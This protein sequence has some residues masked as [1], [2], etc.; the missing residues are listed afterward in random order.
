MDK[1]SDRFDTMIDQALAR[2]IDTSRLDSQEL[3]KLRLTLSHCDPFFLKDCLDS[4]KEAAIIMPMT[5]KMRQTV[6]TDQEDVKIHATYSAGYNNKD[7]LKH[8]LIVD[9]ESPVKDLVISLAHELTHFIQATNGRY[10]IDFDG[11]P[12]PQELVARYFLAEAEAFAT[13]IDHAYEVHIKDPQLSH[14]WLNAEQRMPAFCRLYKEVRTKTLSRDKAFKATFSL[15]YYDEDLRQAMTDVALHQYNLILN[16][17]HGNQVIDMDWDHY[18][19]E[20]IWRGLSILDILPDYD[21]HSALYG[22]LSPAFNTALESLH[23]AIAKSINDARFWDIDF[24]DALEPEELSELIPFL[25]DVQTAPEHDAMIIFD[26]DGTLVN[27]D[28]VYANSCADILNDHHLPVT[29]EEMVHDFGG[30]SSM[31]RIRHGYYQAGRDFNEAEA[32][33]I[34]EKLRAAKATIYSDHSISAFNG[35]EKL[36][37]TLKDK[38]IKTVLGTSNRVPTL[39]TALSPEQTG[40]GKYF[41]MEDLYCGGTLLDEGKIDGM[42]PNPGNF[43]YAAE[44]Q[45]IAPHKVLVIGNSIQDAIGAK[46]AEMPFIGYIDSSH[47]D[48]D[49]IDCAHTQAMMREGAITVFSDFK[50]LQKFIFSKKCP[51]NF[52]PKSKPRKKPVLIATK[53]RP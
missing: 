5:A 31:D 34:Q 47:K 23:G 22:G 48:Y 38:D 51:I 29:Y 33:N 35:V 4:T 16:N 39:L 30:S 7:E 37:Q 49:Q 32:K 26:F 42:K 14:F 1:S 13:M 20:P 2:L 8:Y 17:Y 12:R 36:L 27:S 25:V 43:T 19:N 53:P 11:I 9:L 21:A 44:E 6:Q 10:P 50:T 24:H 52:E 3:N 46:A 15:F 41:E 28:S 40:L 45:A 18:I